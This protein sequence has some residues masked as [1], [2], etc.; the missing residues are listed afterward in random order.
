MKRFLLTCVF[1]ASIGCGAIPARKHA[2]LITWKTNGNPL[3]SAC[4][5]PLKNCISGITVLD[6]NTE[7]AIQ[8]R[9]TAVSYMAPNANHTYEIRVNGYDLKGHTI[10]SKY[11]VVPVE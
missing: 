1:L 5:H 4:T 2:L 9:P 6:R 11:E 10:S 7:Q 8:L 3:V